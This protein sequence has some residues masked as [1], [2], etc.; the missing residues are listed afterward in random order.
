MLISAQRAQSPAPTC[1]CPLAPPPPQAGPPSGGSQGARAAIKH[2]GQPRC[3]GHGCDGHL[4]HRLARLAQRGQQDRRQHIAAHS[5]DDGGCGRKIHC[6]SQTAMCPCLRSCAGPTVRTVSD[7]GEVVARIVARRRRTGLDL[8]ATSVE[9]SDHLATVHD[10]RDGTPALGVPK[11][12][13]H[14]RGVLGDVDVLKGNL[15]FAVVLTGGRGVGSSV[16]AE[17]QRF[18]S[19]PRQLLV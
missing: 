16:L 6:R 5:S 14:P 9:S 10:Q 11:H 18:L 2:A 1:R 4:P 12:L 8:S 13:L 15:P 17:D 3:R 7:Y 19:H